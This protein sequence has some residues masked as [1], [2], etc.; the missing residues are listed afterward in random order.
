MSEADSAKKAVDELLRDLSACIFCEPLELQ[1]RI[2]IPVTR[3][4]LAV[5][6]GRGPSDAGISVSGKSQ[7]SGYGG[8]G[9]AGGLGISPAGAVVIHR[10]I[11]GQQGVE[12][13]PLS[14]GSERES[15][16]SDLI[17][18]KVIGSIRRSGL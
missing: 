8:L 1:D 18:E 5:G 16:A 9:A 13:L 2:I 17:L 3:L 11:A 14:T 6:A 12:F 10:C 4:S 7:P 15:A